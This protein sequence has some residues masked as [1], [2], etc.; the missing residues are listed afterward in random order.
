MLDLISSFCLNRAF[1]YPHI[2]IIL[3]NTVSKFSDVPRSGKNFFRLGVTD[4]DA[5]E[6]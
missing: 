3:P 1:C 6:F 4:D 5:F 2:T